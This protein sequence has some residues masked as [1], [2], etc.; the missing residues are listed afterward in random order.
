MFCNYNLLNI[1]EAEEKDKDQEILLLQQ[2]FKQVK[3]DNEE[4]K[5]R[6]LAFER[7]SEE[8][9]I[10]RKI[11]E[12]SDVLKACYNSAQ[13]DITKLIEEKNVLLDKIQKM[14]ELLKQKDSGRQWNNKR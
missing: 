2:L 6:L 5:R 4:L 1:L 7:I 12:E 10:L 13:D 14:D 3:T 8:N 11:K 9:R